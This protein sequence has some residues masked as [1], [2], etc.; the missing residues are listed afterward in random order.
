MIFFLHIPKTAG[1]TFYEVVNANHKRFLK[2]KIENSP[3]EYLQNN[4]RNK[5]TAIRLPGG[6][7][8]APQTLQIIEKLPLMAL[9]NISFIGGHV[10]FGF[11]NHTDLELKYI[12][13]IRNP[14][15]RIFS[16]YRE[17][18]KKGRYFYEKLKSEHFDFNT[19]LLALKEEKMDNILTRQLAGPYDF[20]LME[21][22]PVDNA[23]Y[24]RAKQNVA[25]IT[26]FRMEDFDRAL[27]YL[28]Q[29]FDWEKTKYI[30][31]NES[32]S[33]NNDF[34]INEKLLNEII[35]FDLKLYSEITPL[36]KTQKFHIR[37]LLGGKS[38]L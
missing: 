6:Y 10:G 37:N 9:Q 29:Q 34:D 20:F 8:S 33:K 22:K 5:N 13:F 2:P 17:H 21:R 14:R 12:S 24:E 28:K 35:E 18:C 32:G 23:L 36:Q 3:G 4:I 7:A 26:F 16:D 11:H 25:S 15:E 31:K 19:Y 27:A 38:E 30:R 1:T